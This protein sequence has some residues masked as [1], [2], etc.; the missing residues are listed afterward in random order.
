MHDIERK[1]ITIWSDEMFFFG[2]TNQWSNMF[3]NFRFPSN[4]DN[5][6]TPFVSL[7]YKTPRDIMIHIIYGFSDHILH[8]TKNVKKVIAK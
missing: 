1:Y 8:R 3:L 6:E 2:F 4:F 7:S 5:I